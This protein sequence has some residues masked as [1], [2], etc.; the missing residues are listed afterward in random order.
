[1]NKTSVPPGAGSLRHRRE[2]IKTPVLSNEVYSYCNLYEMDVNSGSK[3]PQREE[4]LPAPR[5][6]RDRGWW[7]AQA[8]SRRSIK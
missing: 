7:V 1:M 6:V 8:A 4:R 3:I 2:K 5:L